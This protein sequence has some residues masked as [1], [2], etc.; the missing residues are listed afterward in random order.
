VHAARNRTGVHKEGAECAVVN[1]CDA[2]DVVRT[3]FE[4]CIGSDGM[5]NGAYGMIR[6]QPLEAAGCGAGYKYAVGSM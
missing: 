5:M 1:V 6:R 2:G 3:W 4:K